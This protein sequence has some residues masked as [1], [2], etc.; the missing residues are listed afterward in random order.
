MKHVV[1][2]F[3]FIAALLMCAPVPAQVKSKKVDTPVTI[4]GNVKN[5]KGIPLHG[6]EVTVQDSFINTDTDENGDF[7][8]ET[9]IGSVLA[10]S[11]LYYND[12]YQ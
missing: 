9:T 7:V 2:T 3:L 6:V 5:T 4:Y 11:L 1:R 12:S 10:F 8:I